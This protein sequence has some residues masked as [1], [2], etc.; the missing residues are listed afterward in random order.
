MNFE[1]STNTKSE[2]KKSNSRKLS[3]SENENSSVSQGKGVDGFI[4]LYDLI[5]SGIKD[6]IKVKIFTR[7]YD[8]FM[9]DEIKWS[10]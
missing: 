4:E 6:E 3:T 1:K 7:Y 5:T 8:P 9:I 10:D 2:T